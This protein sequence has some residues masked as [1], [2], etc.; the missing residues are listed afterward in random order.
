MLPSLPSLQE[1]LAK[2]GDSRS[3]N[4]VILL[5]ERPVSTIKYVA[6]MAAGIPILHVQ[7]AVHSLAAQKP[8]ASSQKFQEDQGEWRPPPGPLPIDRY[9]IDTQHPEAPPGTA[10]TQPRPHGV[11][12]SNPLG[13]ESRVA[14]LFQGWRFFVDVPNPIRKAYKR[15]VE[16]LLTIAGAEVTKP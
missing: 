12:K 5:C 7:W 13:L 15:E 11:S 4:R 1:S 10:A 6:A 14:P 3:Q 2:R 16:A 9:A 8:P